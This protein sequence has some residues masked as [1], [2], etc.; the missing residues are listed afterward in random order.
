MGNEQSLLEV[1][2]AVLFMKYVI[3]FLILFAI[4]KLLVV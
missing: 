4:I 3:D 1:K 2:E